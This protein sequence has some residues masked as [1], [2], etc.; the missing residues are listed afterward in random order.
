[1]IN[2]D[3]GRTP[4]RRILIRLMC[5]P[6]LGGCGTIYNVGS[7]EL[8]SGNT[9]SCGCLRRDTAAAANKSHGLNAHP[10]YSVWVNMLARC[11]NPAAKD[12][13]NYG[14]RT[15]PIT[16]WDPWHDVAVFIADVEA[17]IGPGPGRP[18]SERPADVDVRPHR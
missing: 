12:Y 13:P 6:D 16:V 2:P 1:M 11:E 8:R 3:V 18:V 17:E 10:L 15:P 5:A 14:G 9:R 7:V 4:S